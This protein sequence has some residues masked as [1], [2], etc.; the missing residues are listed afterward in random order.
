MLNKPSGSL[1][2]GEFVDQLSDCW[3][4]LLVEEPLTLTDESWYHKV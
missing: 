4:D 2:C 1:N 3:E